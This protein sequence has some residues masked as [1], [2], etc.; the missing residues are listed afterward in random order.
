MEIPRKAKLFRVVM[1]RKL[2]I[3][4]EHSILDDESDDSL[5]TNQVLA[6]LYSDVQTN[7]KHNETVGA[8]SGLKQ[9][10]MFNRHSSSI[11]SQG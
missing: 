9:P 11:N 7:S 10:F 1:E 3:D 6:D 2:G 5:Q 8:L 4:W